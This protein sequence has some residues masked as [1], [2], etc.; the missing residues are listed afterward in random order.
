[1]RELVTGAIDR[2]TALSRVVVETRQYAK[3]QR[4]WFRHQLRDDQLHRLTP[5]RSGWQEKV[6]RWIAEIEGEGAM[7]S[8]ERT[9]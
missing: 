8:L 7:N 9:R 1:M 2:D 4:T 5:Q 6:D 3:R